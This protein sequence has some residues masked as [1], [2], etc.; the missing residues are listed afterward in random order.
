MRIIFMSMGIAE[1]HQETIT[2]E[3][4]NVSVKT[5]DDFRTSSLIHTDDFS[6][7]FGIELCRELRGVHQITEHDRELPSFRGGRRRG[8]NARCALRGWLFLDSRLWCG[9]S[10]LSNGFL[11]ASVAP[12]HT[13]PRPASSRT[14]CA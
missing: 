4:G 5:L 13:S 12:V 11:D 10:W 8:R 9:L 1:V 2:Q 14:A 3:L 7:L 6:I